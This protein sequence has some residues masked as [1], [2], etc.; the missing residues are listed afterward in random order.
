MK[1]TIS[2]I[3]TVLFSGE[4]LSATVPG[5]AGEMT[6]LRHHMPLITT[7]KKGKILVKKDAE[8]AEEIPLE[9]GFAYTDGKQLVVLAE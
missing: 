9:S 6:V 2:K 5:A 3:D 1:L 8:T 7:L 4:V